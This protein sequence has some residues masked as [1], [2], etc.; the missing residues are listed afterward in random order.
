MIV[1]VYWKNGIESGYLNFSPF[2]AFMLAIIVHITLVIQ[3]TIIIGIPTTIKQRG[4][5]KIIYNKIDI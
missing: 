2:E 4:I 5:I 1:T 3:R